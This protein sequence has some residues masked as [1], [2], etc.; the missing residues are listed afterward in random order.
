MLSEGR[1]A[2]ATPKPRSSQRHPCFSTPGAQFPSN[3][4]CSHERGGGGVS[5]EGSSHLSSTQGHFPAPVY[6]TCFKASV[7]QLG[8]SGSDVT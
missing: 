1:R 7:L 5:R 6:D 8:V 4:A 2:H 3:N